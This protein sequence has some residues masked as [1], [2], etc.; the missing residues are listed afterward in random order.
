MSVLRVCDNA[1]FYIIHISV[2]IVYTC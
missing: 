2:S 1:G